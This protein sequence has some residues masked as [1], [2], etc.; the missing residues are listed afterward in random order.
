MLQSSTSA[1]LAALDAIARPTD[2]PETVELLRDR[3]A[4]RPE[5]LWEKLGS[6]SEVETPAEQYRRLRLKTLEVERDGGAQDPRPAGPS[7][8]M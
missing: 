2:A 1:A 8:T 6:R 3:I 5:A 7:T 4:A